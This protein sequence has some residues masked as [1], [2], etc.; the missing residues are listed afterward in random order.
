MEQTLRSLVEILQK[1]VPTI[2]LLLLVYFYFKAMLFGPLNKVL[3][4]RDELTKG[5][6]QAAEDSLA[7]AERKTMEFEAKL[8]DARAEV[9]KEQEEQRR[10]WLDEQTLQV[11]QAHE[12]GAELVR[13]ARQQVAAEAASARETLVASSGALADEIAASLL[14][15]RRQ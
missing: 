10:K 7:S 12:R 4:Q 9:Y 15:G 5:A 13:T 1:A 2:L 8:R 11:A 14:A 3:K 6:R